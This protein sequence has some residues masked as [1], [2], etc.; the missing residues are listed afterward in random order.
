MSVAF[1]PDDTPVPSQSHPTDRRTP[2]NVER[3]ALQA[4]ARQT[5]AVVLDFTGLLAPIHGRLVL[6]PFEQGEHRPENLERM[7]DAADLAAILMRQLRLLTGPAVETER[8]EEPPCGVSIAAD[9]ATAGS[10]ATVNG[11]AHS[12]SAAWSATKSL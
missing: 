12:R 4:I 2:R 6:D 1:G 7:S 5:A 8:V 10:S 3:L 11:S 9:T